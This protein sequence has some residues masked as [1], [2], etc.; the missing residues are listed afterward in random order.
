MF[1][2]HKKDR[3]KLNK[4]DRQTHKTLKQIGREIE[5]QI[6]REIGKLIG[7][8]RKKIDEKM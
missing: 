3:G 8:E 4:T 7:T 2:R 5:Q 1:Y 6:G